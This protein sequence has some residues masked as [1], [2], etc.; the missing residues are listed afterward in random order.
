M[1]V[2]AQRTFNT[3]YILSLIHIFLHNTSKGVAFPFFSQRMYASMTVS[4]THLF[5]RAV[6]IA[7]TAVIAQPFPQLQK[8]FFR[9]RCERLHGGQFAHK[10]LV[11]FLDRLHARLLQHDLRNPHAVC[12]GIFAPGKVAL[13][14]IV[15]WQKQRGQFLQ[16]L[17]SVHAFIIPYLARF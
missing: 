6:Q 15:P 16:D 13:V 17:L 3:A 2:I 5:R 4:Y 9:A 1:G 7:G 11:M 14:Y 10:P 12:V 8:F